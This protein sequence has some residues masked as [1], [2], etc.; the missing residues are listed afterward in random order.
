MKLLLC[1]NVD[2][3]GI[4]GDVVEVAAGYAR[5]YLLPQGIATEPTEVN[6]RALAD[7]RRTAEL[8]RARE[9]TEL[10][11]LAEKLEGV[12]VTIRA[13]A[14]EEGA[15]Y[16]SVGGREIVEALAD[17]GYYIKF[18]QVTLERPIR[19]LDTISVDVRLADDLSSA[20]K[21]WIV[22]DK[23]EQEGDDAETD[24]DEAGREAGEDDDGAPE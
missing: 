24:E 17:E 12:E 3:L 9:R 6:M 16:G 7:A 13:R 4:V 2:K 5:N 20:I 18:E 8:E 14:N 1:K 15:L 23:T 11:Q 21:V 22:P 19:H 10:E